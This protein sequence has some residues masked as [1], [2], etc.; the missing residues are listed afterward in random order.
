MKWKGWE[1]V[2]LPVLDPAMSLKIKTV[3]AIAPVIISASR[4]TDIPAFYGD[5]FMER[6]RAG[7]VKWKSP[8]GGS[9][10][11]VSF[12]K[13]R[14]F[15]F[16]SKNPAPFLPHLDT[17]DQLDYRYYFLFTLNNYDVEGLEPNVPPVDDRI[18]S[19]IRLSRRIGKGRVVWRFDPLVLSDGITID[20]LLEKVRYIGDQVAPF[21]ERLVFSFVDIEKYAKV[22]RNLQAGSCAGAREFTSEEVAEFCTGL[23]ALNK[24]W[25]LSVSACAEPGDLS[26][27]GIGRG[28]CISYD[29]LTKEFI[30]DV[31]LRDFLS[32][33]GQQELAGT[34]TVIDPSL[35]LKDSGQ[36]NTCR[37][38]V[39]KD[40]GQY[41]T[42]PHLCAYCYANSSPVRVS[43]NYARYCGERDHGFFHDSITE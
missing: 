31:V 14:V 24:R 13:T 41:S 28:Q 4:S 1:R 35:R 16:W 3:E 43:R 39:S 7:Y 18:D 22:R 5:W 26:G 27:Y 33:P 30:D 12:A 34:G 37:C 2:P 9:P 17:L 29:L 42:C 11:F 8:F 6:L 23:I 38:I 20:D 15:V 21:T 10:V 25:K 32:P 19:F 36:R 40:I